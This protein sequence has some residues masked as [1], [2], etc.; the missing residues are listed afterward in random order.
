MTSIWEYRAGDHGM[1]LDNDPVLEFPL[2]SY[3]NTV[4]VTGGAFSRCR[5]FVLSCGTGYLLRTSQVKITSTTR[6]EVYVMRTQR[7]KAT[8]G[9][10]RRVWV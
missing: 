7:K 3:F 8:S 4:T 5:G 9:S 1:K 2:L 6:L 10:S